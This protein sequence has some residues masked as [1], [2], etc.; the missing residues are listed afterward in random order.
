MFCAKE[1]ERGKKALDPRK[2]GRNLCMANWKMTNKLYFDP[3]NCSASP[4]KCI[5]FF[6]NSTFNFYIPV[7]VAFI[8]WILCFYFWRELICYTFW[9]FKCKNGHWPNHQFY[10]FLSFSAEMTTFRG[11]LLHFLVSIMIR[12]HLSAIL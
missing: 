4:S 3:D 7:F 12:K 1:G 8:H 2:E 9:I 10:H 11:I 6:Y 5:F